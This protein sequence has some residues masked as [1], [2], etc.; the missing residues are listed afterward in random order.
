MADTGT[1]GFTVISPEEAAKLYAAKKPSG[2]K[3][4]SASEAGRLMASKKSAAIPDASKMT[5]AQAVQQLEGGGL[6]A[7]AV[8]PIDLLTFGA[9]GGAMGAAKGPAEAG[10]EALKEAGTVGSAELWNQET[11]PIVQK[12]IPGQG[13]GAQMARNLTQTAAGF[14]PFVAAGAGP[15]A[16]KGAFQ[17]VGG[18][19]EIAEQGIKAGEKASAAAESAQSKMADTQAKGGAELDKKY[20][21]FRQQQIP[22]AKTDAQVEV[23][24]GTLGRTPE[25]TR[26]AASANPADFAQRQS[27][28]RGTILEKKNEVEQEFQKEYEDKFGKYNDKPMALTTAAQK[29]QSMLDWAKTNNIA[30]SPATRKLLEETRDMSNPSGAFNPVTAGISAKDWKRLPPEE[31]QLIIRNTSK[32]KSS[33]EGPPTKARIMTS[34]GVPYVSPKGTVP[35]SPSMP[36]VAQV[37]GL[38]SKFG[39]IAGAQGGDGYVARQMR[40]SIMTDL[41]NSGVPGAKELNNR[42]RVFRSGAGLGDYDFLGKVSDP[43]GGDITNMA[44]EI[45]KNPQ[46]M[47]EFTK[48]L[49]PE[50][51]GQWR[52]VYG[53]Y[54]NNGGAV[55]A[56]QLKALGFQGPL[57]KPDAWVYLNKSEQKLGDVFQNSPVAQKKF[58][59]SLENQRGQ[60]L[61]DNSKETL[62]IAREMASKLGATGDRIMAKIEAAKTP[63]EA[64]KIAYQEFGALNPAEEG[65]A[66]GVSAIQNA[67]TPQG[68]LMGRL[69]HRAEIYSILAL[70]GRPYFMKLALLLG[71]GTGIHEV[72]KA[73]V[74]RSLRDPAAAT[75]L[76]RAYIEPGAK[77]SLDTITRNIAVSALPAETAQVGQAAT[78]KPKGPGPMV[79]QVEHE[80]AVNIAGP[81]GAVSPARTSR[82]EDLNKDIAE[83]K[84]PEVHADLRNGRLTHTDIAKMVQPDKGGVAGLFQGM[85]PTQAVDA[86]AVADPSE[87]E[88]GLSALAQHLQDSAKTTDPKQM[89]IA[90][91]KLKSIMAQ[92]GDAA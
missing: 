50:Q 80:K 38:N 40:D 7:P 19:S 52:E 46:R 88:L 55:D 24:Q 6:Q 28:L 87:R 11:A 47:N 22:G 44:G 81:R 15:Q 91:Q 61:A 59:A 72:L 23:T 79:K 86:F 63:E 37:R 66:A 57:T 71:T 4:I 53:D 9:A 21:Q 27:E 82:I 76:Y 49:T 56:D 51:K 2:V 12:A 84:E 32:L 68:G 13:P 70:S 29:A 65:Q 1:A 89:A 36:T 62:K 16:A 25:Q 92:Q 67:S 64:A 43:K 77:N 69:K 33:V 26:A 74:M 41:D 10:L 73:S 85:T 8:D 34:Q 20:E 83:G 18:A 5:Q 14:V 75:Q 54:V 48:R 45:F 30:L 42:Y 31:Q 90:M 60:L 3:T 35:V 17:K 39:E 78:A 58:L